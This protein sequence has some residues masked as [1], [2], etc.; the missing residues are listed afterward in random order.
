MTLYV[1]E[2]HATK[3]EE[4]GTCGIYTTLVKARAKLF[5]MIWEDDDNVLEDDGRYTVKTEEFLYFIQP[6]KLDR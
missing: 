4:H 2:Y 3:E 6:W 5:K 1:I